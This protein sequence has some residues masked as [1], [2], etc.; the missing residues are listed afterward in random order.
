MIQG[1]LHLRRLAVHLLR[2]AP[3]HELVALGV[4]DIVIGKLVQRIAVRILLAAIP[5]GEA[6]QV[7]LS[8]FQIVG[9]VHIAAGGAVFLCPVTTR[10]I[11]G[12]IHIDHIQERRFD[13]IPLLLIDL[14]GHSGHFIRPVSFRIQ[15]IMGH[16]RLGDVLIY[17]SIMILITVLHA[18]VL[19]PIV[20]SEDIISDR[21]H[22]GGTEIGLQT[23]SAH[24]IR[25]QG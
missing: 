7:R 12:T 3:D 4:Q 5:L 22:G 10:D 14:D 17:S 16:R 11:I 20:I 23:V 8:P 24:C 25:I 18:A 1:H 21:G 9:I 15:R 6:E 19:H 13:G 2:L